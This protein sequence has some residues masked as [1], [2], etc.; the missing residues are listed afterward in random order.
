MADLFYGSGLDNKK[1]K[2]H[3]A[4]LHVITQN[5]QGFKKERRSGWLRGWKQRTSLRPADVIY[6][7]DTHLKTSEEIDEVAEMWNRVWGI[8]E[9]KQPLSYWSK[10]EGS[11][12]CIGI[13]L[14]PNIAAQV[15]PW[16][17]S[18]WTGRRIGL[19]FREWT[20][21]NIYAPT[22]RKAQR[23]FYS[24][25]QSWIS[26]V[27]LLLLGGD[28]NAVL[29]PSLDRIING[30]PSAKSCESVELDRLVDQLDLLDAVQLTTHANEDSVPD[31]LTHLV[32]GESSLQAGWITSI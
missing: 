4:E 3:R 28:F 11:S 7:Q 21:V 26:K 6:V 30:L 15:S 1:N 19:R 2:Q 32:F 20:L 22:D 18:E 31:P 17:P 23:S 13:L 14:Q 25:L 9:P 24:D 12:G 10:M 27:K 16:R 8:K 29:Q 5:L